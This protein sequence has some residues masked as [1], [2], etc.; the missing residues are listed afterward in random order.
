MVETPW[1][2]RSERNRP[3]SEYLVNRGRP[4]GKHTYVCICSKMVGYTFQAVCVCVYIVCV[5]TL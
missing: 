4:T 5:G 2:D 1:R 3:T